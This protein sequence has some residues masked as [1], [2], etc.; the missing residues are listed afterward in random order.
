MRKRLIM[1]MIGLFCLTPVS[2]A[3]PRYGISYS[4][5]LIGTVPEHLQGYK[6][7]IW[8]QPPAL[9]WEH[10]HILFDLSYGHW[11]VNH[12]MINRSLSTYALAPVFRYYFVTN[13][14]FSPFID[15]SIGLTYMT[16]SRLGDRNLGMYFSFQDQLGLGVSFGTKQQFSVSLSAIH[17]SNG[18][19][20]GR[21]SGF[22]APL[23]LNAEYGFG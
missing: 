20:C 18:C 8:Y 22:T 6:T 17:Y 5:T 1:L 11:W 15:A 3:A 13:N 9:A 2:F 12:S 14:Y 23:M 10:L 16:R 7:S 19:I 4:H 21:N